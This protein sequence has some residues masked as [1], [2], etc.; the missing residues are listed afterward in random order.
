MVDL[1]QCRDDNCKAVAGIGGIRSLRDESA[2]SM[3]GASV[4]AASMKSASVRYMA[5]SSYA[6]QVKMR[7]ICASAKC[8]CVD[9]AYD[10]AYNSCIRNVA[11]ATILFFGR[12][13]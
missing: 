11:C 8:A 10:N 7:E 1:A 9:S 13:I 5:A 4:D 6:L 3:P 2:E 12:G